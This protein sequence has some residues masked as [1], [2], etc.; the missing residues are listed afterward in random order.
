MVQNPPSALARRGRRGELRAG[1]A[2]I[3]EHL[4]H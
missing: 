2:R 4:T 3:T 1:V